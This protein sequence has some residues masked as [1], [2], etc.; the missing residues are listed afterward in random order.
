MENGKNNPN[1]QTG[2]RKNLSASYRPIF[3]LNILSKI[4]DKSILDKNLEYINEN[5]LLNRDQFGFRENHSTTQQLFKITNTILF[6]KQKNHHTII[7]CLDLEKA[8][9]TIYTDGLIHRLYEM[10]FPTRFK[11]LVKSYTLNRTYY[12]QANHQISTKSPITVG[13]PI[14]AR[15]SPRIRPF[16]PLYQ[17]Y[18][19]P[20]R[21]PKIQ[22]PFCGRHR[23]NI[24][25]PQ[26][27]H[28][29]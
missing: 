25:V 28:H 4:L 29:Q 22:R 14:T 20:H 26:H 2:K 18:T 12:V 17:Q 16:L 11:Q 23:H 21:S 9:D 6:N 15:I 24:H 13:S 1:T 27:Q 5:D 10:K 3:L 8:F 7:T 19:H